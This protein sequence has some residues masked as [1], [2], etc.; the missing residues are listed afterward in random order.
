[1]A[2]LRSAN[3]LQR[4]HPAALVATF[5]SGRLE[6][7]SD[8]RLVGIYQDFHPDRSNPSTAPLQGNRVNDGMDIT[9]LCDSHGW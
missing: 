1:M 4:Q 8:W 5:P 6:G 7:Q 3:S 9:S 2:Y